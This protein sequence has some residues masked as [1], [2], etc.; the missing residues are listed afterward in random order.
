MD[1]SMW[2][3]RARSR[4][5][6]T[7]RSLGAIRGVQWTFSIH[8]AYLLKSQSQ[9]KKSSWSVWIFL[10]FLCH[11]LHLFGVFHIKPQNERVYTSVSVCSSYMYILYKI[12]LYKGSCP[13]IGWITFIILTIYRIR[14]QK[15]Y[16]TP[17]GLARVQKLFT[18][19]LIVHIYIRVFSISN[20]IFGRL[21]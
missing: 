1:Q 8:S 12:N 16:C 15:S 10:N 11:L 2:C 4:T 6:S 13:L 19:A 3:S 17:F 21:L 7:S 5:K 14:S 20:A 9:N 18:I